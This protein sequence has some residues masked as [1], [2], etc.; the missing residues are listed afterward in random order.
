MS[1]L[2]L[3]S[4]FNVTADMILKMRLSFLIFFLYFYF[5]LLVCL[6]MCLPPDFLPSIDHTYSSS[7][8]R[9][10][11]DS[12]SPSWHPRTHSG[13]TL[14]LQRPEVARSSGHLGQTMVSS[15]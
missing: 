8:T 11:P 1:A 12:S 9:D 13:K 5:S 14:R 7:S 4:H 2:V 6:Y 10:L 3:T 15:S